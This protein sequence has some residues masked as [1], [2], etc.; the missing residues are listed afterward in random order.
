MAY[1]ITQNP[2]YNSIV[3]HY[4]TDVQ[5]PWAWTPTAGNIQNYT[6]QINSL[7]DRFSTLFQNSV[8]R[9]PNEA[10]IATFVNQ[11]VVPNTSNLAHPDSLNNQFQDQYLNNFVGSTYAQAAQDEATKKLQGQQSQYNDLANLFRNQ[12]VSAINNYS[13]A[14]D[15]G[16]SDTE[17]QLMD[18]Q[19][20]LFDKL[21][22]NLITSLQAQGLLD[23]GG[24]NQALA[25]AQKDLSNSAQDTLISSRLN[26]AQNVANLKLENDQAANQIAQGAAMQP[27][28]FQ[29]QMALNQVPNYYQQGQTAMQ[30]VY[31]QITDLNSYNRQIGL[32]QLQAKLQEDAQPSFLKTLGQNFAASTGNSLGQWLSPNPGGNSSGGSNN[33]LYMK[34]Y[35]KG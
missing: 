21:R 15:K 9:A 32:M 1:D 14:M 8:G 11:Y 30:N 7:T 20:R 16:L 23:T 5:V 10:E 17:S 22:P 4:K 19:G 24:L 31:N 28:D 3:Q 25:G 13:S 34:L 35:G 33:Q 6:N 29:R 27:L 2:E 26:A 12:G 18:F